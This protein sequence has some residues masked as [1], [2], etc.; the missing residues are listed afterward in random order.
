MVLMEWQ[1]FTKDR[2]NINSIYMVVMSAG[3]L[4]KLLRKVLS[5]SE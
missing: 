2:S 4:T 3:R 1:W 5:S